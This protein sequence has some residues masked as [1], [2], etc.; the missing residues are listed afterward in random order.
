M[1]GIR[2]ADA[3]PLLSS[4]PLPTPLPATTNP[5]QLLLEMMDAMPTLHPKLQRVVDEQQA[6]KTPTSQPEGPLE[7]LH[8]PSPIPST[9]SALTSATEAPALISISEQLA[10]SL[11]A[12]TTGDAAGCGPEI[13]STPP[14]SAPMVAICRHKVQPLSSPSAPTTSATALCGPNTEL[15][16]PTSAPTATAR[17]GPDWIGNDATDAQF[18]RSEHEPLFPAQLGYSS[19]ARL[20]SA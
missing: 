10:L 5:V 19:P 8:A 12:S 15:A 9:L 16:S 4:P 7:L 20:C 17:C 1:A 18:I 3:Q 2:S 13:R 14:S 6:M 11:A